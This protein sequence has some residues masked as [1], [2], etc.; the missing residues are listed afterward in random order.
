[1]A[2]GRARAGALQLTLRH[3]PRVLGHADLGV[4]SI[5]LPGIEDAEVVNAVHGR[6]APMMPAGAGLRL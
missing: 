2:V 3:G 1:V 4:T 6:R 5:Y